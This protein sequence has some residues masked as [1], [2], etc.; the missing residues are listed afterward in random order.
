MSKIVWGKFFWPDWQNDPCL[1]LCSRAARGLW[2]DLLCIAAQ[3]DTPGYV[4]LN[5]KPL[6]AKCIALLSA[7][8]ENEIESLLEELENN[9]VFSRDRRGCIMSRRMIRERCLSDKAK[10]NGS[11]G[12]NP[13]LGKQTEKTIPVNLDLNHHS[14]NKPEAISQKLNLDTN[15][16]IYNSLFSELMHIL[17]K[18]K[19]DSPKNVRKAFDRAIKTVSDFSEIKRGAIAYAE[20]RKGEDRN[21][22]KG[23]EAWFNG[24]MWQSDWT[25][26]PRHLAQPR[27]SPAPVSAPAEP[28]NAVIRSLM[29]Q[30]QREADEQLNYN[31]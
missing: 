27:G 13:S 10:I 2:I 20:S 21:Y 23:L 17:P 19:G 4:A 14:G 8:P 7:G 5:G 16:S 9:G 6:D 25:P 29:R 11:K 12:G 31:Q 1:R 18:R 28:Q 15:V 26:S 3:S 24:A 30:K 22:N